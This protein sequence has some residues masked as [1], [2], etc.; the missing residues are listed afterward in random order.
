MTPHTSK[1]LMAA[2]MNPLPLEEAAHRNFNP[3]GR[4]KRRRLVRSALYASDAIT[5]QFWNVFVQA[6]KALHRKEA[7]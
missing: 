2:G 5:E 4:N 6:H 3:V 1:A 7:A